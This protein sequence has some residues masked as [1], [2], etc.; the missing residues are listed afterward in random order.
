MHRIPSSF[1]VTV[2]ERPANIPGA[3]L[4]ANMQFTFISYLQKKELIR[5]SALHDLGPNKLSLAPVQRGYIINVHHNGQF[6][7][8][9][10]IKKNIIL[11]YL[12][13]FTIQLLSK[14]AL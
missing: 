10:S 8:K 1:S 5:T 13:F 4:L 3:Y 2:N 6:V 9:I 12:L 11:K 14:C 7:N